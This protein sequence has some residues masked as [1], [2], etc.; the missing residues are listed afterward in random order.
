MFGLLAFVNNIDNSNFDAIGQFESLITG[1]AHV[2]VP[3]VGTIVAVII[4]GL[5]LW[6]FRNGGQGW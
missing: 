4:L 2:L 6:V 3:S 1:M 5:L